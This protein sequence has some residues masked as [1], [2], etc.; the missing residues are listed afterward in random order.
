MGFPD[1]EK[2]FI[3]SV[4]AFEKEVSDPHLSAQL[5]AFVQQEAQHS[6]QHR[7]YNDVFVDQ[8]TKEL[9]AKQQTKQE[10]KRR[11]AVASSQSGSSKLSNLASTV[12]FEHL[13]AVFT[14]QLLRN[15]NLTAGMSA[16]VRPLW[17]WHAIEETEHKA[18]AFDIYKNVGGGYWRRIWCYLLA[19]LGYPCGIALIQVFLLYQEGKLLDIRDCIRY[20]RFM[21]GANGLVRPMLPGL[22]LYF[23]RS[24]HPWQLDNRALVEQWRDELEPYTYHKEPSAPADA[25]K[26]TTWRQG[27]TNTVA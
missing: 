9:L 2:F 6:I 25:V 8:N 20:L 18:V 19:V 26:Q 10:E 27:S 5:L 22:L 12:A 16:F 17:I 1:G 21:L 23:R 15:R 7:L 11:S 13:T 4:K 3:E 24:F 14:D